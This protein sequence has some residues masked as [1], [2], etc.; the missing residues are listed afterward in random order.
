MHHSAGDVSTKKILHSADPNEYDLATWRMY[1]RIIDYRQKN[2]LM[3]EPTDCP[4][5][6]KCVM[7]GSLHGPSK[8]QADKNLASSANPPFE[9]IPT[10]ITCDNEDRYDGEVFELDL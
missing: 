10:T 3:N 1:Y 6:P 8:N 9:G 2:Y 4:P 7:S 5:S